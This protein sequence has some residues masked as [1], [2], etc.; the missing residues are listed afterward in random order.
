MV[1]LVLYIWWFYVVYFRVYYIIIIEE[2]K[3]INLQVIDLCRLKIKYCLCCVGYLVLYILDLPRPTDAPKCLRCWIV[4]ERKIVSVFMSIFRGSILSWLSFHIPYHLPSSNVLDRLCQESVTFPHVTIASSHN[5]TI[6]ISFTAA[7][8]HNVNNK[9]LQKEKWR[10]I[11]TSERIS[12][13]LLLCINA[14][15]ANMKPATWRLYHTIWWCYHGIIIKSSTCNQFMF[16]ST[17]GRLFRRTL[18]H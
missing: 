2:T 7:L 17:F 18:W 5:F 6:I 1:V 13:W 15:V 8:I 16:K 12:H 9:S 14:I 10:V 11:I 3:Y 4:S